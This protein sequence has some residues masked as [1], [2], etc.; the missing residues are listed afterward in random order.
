MEFESYRIYPNEE[1]EG[2]PLTPD[3]IF[4]GDKVSDKEALAKTQKAYINQFRSGCSS[5]NISLMLLIADIRK[6][7]KAVSAEAEKVLGI[8]PHYP[9]ICYP[10]LSPDFDGFVSVKHSPKPGHGYT[11]HL[12]EV[13]K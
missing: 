7:V 11:Y 8:E 5:D 10:D 12:I 3:P 1:H 6:K 13:V 4:Q 2:F 9:W